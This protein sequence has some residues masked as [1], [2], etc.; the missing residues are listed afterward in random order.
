MTIAR[1]NPSLQILL[2]EV[3]ACRE[4]EQRL[5]C[6]PRPILAA[7]QDARVLI[8]GQAP[9]RRVHESGVAWDDA[10]GDRLRSWM[11]ITSNIFYDESKI[12]LVPMGFCFPGAGASGDLPPSPECAPLWHDRLLK[13]LTKVKLTLLVGGYAQ[14][15]HLGDQK[16]STLTETVFAWEQHKPSCLPLPHPSPRNNRWL[17]KNSWF[18]ESVLPYLKQRV[19]RLLA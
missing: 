12:A 18:E 6:G 1:H 5:P 15:Y 17:K 9:G 8:I 16:K 13:E 2:E 14:K 10:S 3:R 11:G 7:H 4:C 19:K